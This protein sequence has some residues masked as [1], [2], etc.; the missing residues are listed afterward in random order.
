MTLIERMYLTLKSSAPCR[1]QYERNSAGVPV[2]FK[3]E[4]G[5]IGRKLILQCSP[6]R[7]IE[8]YER[9]QRALEATT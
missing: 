9:E 4:D 7:V 3:N 6:C 1:C 8:E 2:W 5:G